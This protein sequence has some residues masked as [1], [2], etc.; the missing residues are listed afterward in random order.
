MKSIGSYKLL[1]SNSELTPIRI[2]SRIDIKGKNVIKGI[3]LEGLKVVGD[4]GTIA[5]KYYKDGADEIIYMD[6]VAS[7]YGRNNIISVVEE[8]AKDIFIPMTVGGGIRSIED[9][10]SALRGGA[11]KVA[12]N[13]AAVQRP[14]FLSEASE[15]FGKQ[16]IVLSIEAKQRAPGFWEV[17][18]DNGREQTGRNV[19][20]WVREA[21]SLG[22]GE[23][24]VTSIDKEGTQKGFDI[25]LVKSIRE[26]VSVPVIAWGGLVAVSMLERC[27]RKQIV[28]L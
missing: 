21:E 23:V 8:T 15:V 7:L 10:I 25:Q 26:I 22:I 4:P 1:D 11:D 19:L 16:C 9:I 17:L 13:T 6:V 12:I 2:I 5:R 20:D 24:L 3:H 27:L 18:T 14:K 28:M